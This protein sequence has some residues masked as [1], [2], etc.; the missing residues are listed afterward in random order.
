K[1]DSGQSSSGVPCDVDDP[2]LDEQPASKSR[3]VEAQSENI[4]QLER[5]VKL[6]KPIWTYLVNQQ[7]D[8]RKMYINMGPYQPKLEE[9]PPSFD[10]Q[11]L[12]A[13]KWLAKQACAF[14]GH[15]E[16]IKSSNSGN[17]IEMI[18]YSAMM[19]KDIVEVVLEN[20]LGNAKY[21]SSNIQKELLNII[22]NKETSA[23]TLKKNICNVLTRYNLLVEDL[24]GQGYNGASNM[25]DCPYA[26]YVHCFAHRLQLALVKIFKDVPVCHSEL[27]SIREAEI[28]NLIASKELETGTGTNQICS[29][30][31]PGATHYRLISIFDVVHEHLEKMTC[32]GSNNDIRGEAKG[33]YDAMSTFKFF[34]ILH[35]MNKTMELLTLSSALNLVDSFKSFD[36]DDICNLAERFYP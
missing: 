23:S 36:I 24:R 8:V 9:F 35:L 27:K 32:N 19:N 7:D 29:L 33:V 34:F 12:Q 13:V 21:T 18:K 6:R 17:F 1:K 5:D 30:Q 14:R 16:F 20:A 25:R 31:R 4:A 11:Q 3:K 15:D 22:A 2:K 28:I 10:G 26:Y